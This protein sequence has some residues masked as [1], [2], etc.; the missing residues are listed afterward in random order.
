MLRILYLINMLLFKKIVNISLSLKQNLRLLSENIQ[1]PPLYI[2]E[3]KVNRSIT[4]NILKVTGIKLKILGK[5]SKLK[6]Q[7]KILQ[8]QFLTQ[9]SL[10][11]KP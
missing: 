4:Q 9:L 2:Y 1:K 10:A 11:T 6:F 3:R 8:L 7:L 5:E